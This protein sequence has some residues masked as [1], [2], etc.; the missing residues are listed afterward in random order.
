MSSFVVY[1]IFGIKDRIKDSM[2]SLL[3]IATN[4]SFASNLWFFG[5]KKWSEND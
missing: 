5:N 2:F 3:S 1:K 4:F